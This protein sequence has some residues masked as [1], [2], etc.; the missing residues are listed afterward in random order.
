MT[1]DCH[2]SGESMVWREPMSIGPVSLTHLPNSCWLVEVD[3]LNL[4]I[5]SCDGLSSVHNMTQARRPSRLTSNLPAVSMLYALST[6]AISATGFGDL[7]SQYCAL[8]TSPARARGTH[9]QLLV[10][11]SG[12]DH[13][14]I[15]IQPSHA[16][17]RRVVCCYLLRLTRC[18][19]V[20]LDRV[21]ASCR[22]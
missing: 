22:E 16:F 15:R 1:L 7:K 21:V 11:S 18:D 6:K 4:S 13:P 20:H 2:F 3:Q 19:I 10:P 9:S 5:S 8:I 14:S 12:R 17:D